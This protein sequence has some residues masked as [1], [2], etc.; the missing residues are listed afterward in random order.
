[1]KINSV[2]TFIRMCVGGWWS[3]E[4]SI[5]VSPT[6]VGVES[7]PIYRPPPPP[8]VPSLGWGKRKYIVSTSSAVNSIVTFILVRLY[9]PLHM[10]VKYV[11]SQMY[12]SLTLSRLLA[13]GT[14]RLTA[15]LS[16]SLCVHVL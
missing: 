10:C 2:V 15:L 9:V 12:D 7:G 6:S 3:I 8:P 16:H 5:A 13:Q 4:A 1:M 11:L 14:L